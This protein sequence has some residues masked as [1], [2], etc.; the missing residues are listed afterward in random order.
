MQEVG[1]NNRFCKKIFYLFL[2]IHTCPA[3]SLLSFKHP[4]YKV[5][6]LS[7]ECTR[8]FSGNTAHTKILVVISSP[9]YSAFV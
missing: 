1:T 5:L 7:R 4:G 3:N 2:K 9:D 8:F 6:P